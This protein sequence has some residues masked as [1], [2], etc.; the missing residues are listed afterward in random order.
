MAAGGIATSKLFLKKIGAPE[1]TIFV[2]KLEKLGISMQEY[3][4]ADGMVNCVDP[5]QSSS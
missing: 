2:I 3:K 4:N 5:V 1:S